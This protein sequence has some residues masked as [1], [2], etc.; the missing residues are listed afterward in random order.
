MAHTAGNWNNACDSYGKVRHSRKACVYTVIKGNGG[1][2]IETVAARIPNWADAK[3]IRAAKEMY[4]ALKYM[5]HVSEDEG[6]CICP[7][8]DGSK[9]DSQHATSCADARYA[10][11]K[12][13]TNDA[14]VERT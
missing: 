7:L 11:R 3:L 5:N 12:A 13:E 8:N 10:L 9:P 6:Y 1:D 14:M 4:S 2:R